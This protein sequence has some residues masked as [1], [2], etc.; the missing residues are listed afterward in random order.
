[1]NKIRIFIAFICIFAMTSVASA[2]NYNYKLDRPF[3]TKRVIKV[4]GVCDGCQTRIERSARSVTG[5]TYAHWDANKQELLVE[6]NRTRTNPEKI[7]Q[8]IAAKCGA[9]R[10]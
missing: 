1:M 8:V 5:V 9:G 4:S 7:Q 3:L 6:Y 2:Q 10:K